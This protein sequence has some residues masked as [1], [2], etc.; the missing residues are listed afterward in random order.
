MEEHFEYAVR[1]DCAKNDCETPHDDDG[2]V[3]SDGGRLRLLPQEIKGHAVTRVR[4]L[5]GDW[6]VDSDT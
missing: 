4:R 3:W 1:I 6:E 2:L 5:I